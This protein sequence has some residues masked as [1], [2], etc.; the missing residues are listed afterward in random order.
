M[1][2]HLATI[3]GF[4][5]FQPRVGAHVHQQLPTVRQDLP[6]NRACVK[7]FLRWR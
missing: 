1:V 2:T 6:T 7:K 4:E 3:L 5:S